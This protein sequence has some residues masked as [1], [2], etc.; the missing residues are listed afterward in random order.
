MSEPFLGEIRPFA[1]TFAI[2]GWAFCDGSLL[3]IAQNSALFS[4]IGTTYG[5]DG[6]ITFALP[7]LRGRAVVHQGTGPGLSPYV[8]GEMVGQENVTV[9]TGQMAGHTH[10]AAATTAAASS[11]APGPSVVLAATPGGFPIY[12]GT[13]AAVAL[14]TN[15]VSASGGTQP[16]ENRQ[17]YLA[18]SYIIALEGIYPTQN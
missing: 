9:T 8:P 14:A 7:D 16:H 12:D 5:G 10:T 15:A 6:Q 13:A 11:P 17:P 18:L 2:Q 1:G 3:P 4:L